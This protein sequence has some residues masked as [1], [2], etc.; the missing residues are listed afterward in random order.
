[1][2][3]GEQ[4]KTLQSRRPYW[5]LDKELSADLEAALVNERRTRGSP[6][7]SEADLA[8]EALREWL[9]VRGY[10]KSGRKETV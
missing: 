2:S 7:F 3:Y 4:N 10:L 5:R 8:R 6:R 1:V 9:A